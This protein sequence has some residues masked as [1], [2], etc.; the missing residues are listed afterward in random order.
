MPRTA[1]PNCSP[2]ECTSW[3]DLDMRV[4]KQPTRL[5]SFGSNRLGRIHQCIMKVLGDSEACEHYP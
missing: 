2:A 5:V 3:V 1:W 4:T